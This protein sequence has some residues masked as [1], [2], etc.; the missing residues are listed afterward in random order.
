MVCLSQKLT[1]LKDQLLDPAQIVSPHSTVSS[2]DNGWSK[3]ELALALWGADMNVCG[4]V[5]LIRI[6]MKTE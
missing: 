1:V 6:E 5:A 2:Q 3:P 4:L